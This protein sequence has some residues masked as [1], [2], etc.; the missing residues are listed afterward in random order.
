VSYRLQLEGYDPEWIDS[1]NHFITYPNLPPGTYTFKVQATATNHF[2]GAAIKTYS[3]TI[4]PPF[5]KTIW[6]FLLVG[7][8]FAALLVLLVSRREQKLKTQQRYE[9]EKIEF[10]FETLKNQVN[11][12]FLFN[13]FNTLIG[14]IE[15]DKETAIEYVEK[16]SDFY[17]DILVNREKELIPLSKELELLS[18][19]YFLQTKRYKKNLELLVDIPED[20]KQHLISPLTLQLLIENAIKHNVIS[21]DRP[22]VVELFIEEDWVVIRNN[23]QKKVVHEPSTGVGL[24]NITNRYKLLTDKKVVIEESTEYFTVKIPVILAETYGETKTSIRDITS[25]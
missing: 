5:Y 6:F 25:G 20:K 3:F 24:A 16:L 19:Y 17:R 9:K 12:H 21:S 2:D 22:L 4:H 1:K 8:A 11:P 15:E 23:L 7:L 13:S 18:N 10:H 14:V